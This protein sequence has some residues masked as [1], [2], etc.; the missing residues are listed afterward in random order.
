MQNVSIGL[1]RNIV[2]ID[3]KWLHFDTCPRRGAKEPILLMSD[4]N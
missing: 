3:G 4:K 2:K 1:L